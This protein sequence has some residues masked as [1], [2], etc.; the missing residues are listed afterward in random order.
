MKLVGAMSLTR[1]KMLEFKADAFGKMLLGVL[2]ATKLNTPKMRVVLNAFLKYHG[3]YPTDDSLLAWLQ[4]NPGDL[5]G[6]FILKLDNG[7]I[8]FKIV[9]GSQ[10]ELSKIGMEQ[11][12]GTKSNHPERTSCVGEVNLGEATSIVRPGVV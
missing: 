12:N 1:E 9:A 3:L 10:E 2:R 4:E 8:D 6:I 5:I 11:E 7:Q